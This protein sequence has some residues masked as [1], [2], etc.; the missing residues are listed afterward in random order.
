MFLQIEELRSVMYNYQLETIIEND[1]TIAIMAINSAVSE[2]KSY[3]KPSNQKQWNDG[4]P[5][6][7]VDKIFNAQGY[8][9]DALILELCK[10]IALYRICRLANVDIIHEHVKE[11]YDRAIDWL[12]KVAGLKGVPT[13]T[14]DLPILELED[15]EETT[16]KLFRWGSRTKF[17]HE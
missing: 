14:P 12:G 2:M 8:E 6:Y 4:R 5:Q 9:R 10:D 13:L 1:N 17:N 15:S 11:R 3:L 7:D 16:K